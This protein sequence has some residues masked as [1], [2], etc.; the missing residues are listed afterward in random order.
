MSPT[1]DLLVTTIFSVGRFPLELA[2]GFSHVALA[3]HK[4]RSSIPFGVTS[5]NS[6]I[7]QW[8]EKHIDENNTF[9]RMIA[10]SKTLLH[11]ISITAFT[12]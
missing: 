6:A 2:Q 1:G 3:L 11:A 9:V 10:L 7:L 8:M 5:Q 12:S 4:A